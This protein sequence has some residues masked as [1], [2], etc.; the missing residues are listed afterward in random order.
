MGIVALA[1]G[2]FG[3][4]LQIHFEAPVAGT[5]NPVGAGTY[6]LQSSVSATQN[7][8]TLT[9]FTE[10]G[11]GIPYT[12][13]YINSNIVYGTLSPS[14][15]NSEFVSFTGIT[16]NANQTAT[17]SGVI[18]GLART[19]GTGGCVASSTLAH[20]YPGQT[21]FILS[22][23]P[24]FYSQYAVKQN[25]QTIGGLWTFSS[26]SPPKLDYD[27]TSAQ[28]ALF[29]SSTLVTYGQLQATAFAGVTNASESA[30]GIVQLATQTQTGS[31][32]NIGSSGASLVLQS[33]YASSSPSVV[34]GVCTVVTQANG[35]II[36]T[37]INQTSAY[38]WSGLHIFSTGLISTASST[39]TNSSLSIGGLGYTFPSVRGASSTVL[40][41]NGS[42]SLTWESEDLS[43]IYSST[44][45]G[46]VATSS[47]TSI[48]T[49]SYLKILLNIPP[50]TACI[51]QFQFNGDTAANYAYRTTSEFVVAISSAGAKSTIALDTSGTTGLW[52]ELNVSNVANKVKVLRSVG[53]EFVASAS[54]QVAIDTTAT[55]NNTSAQISRI[56]LG[57]G[58]ALP[59]GTTLNIYGSSY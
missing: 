52:S 11:S 49:R 6:V 3:G 39:F 57:C 22:N 17:L 36:S 10:P 56:D 34:C 44:T 7:T 33:Q 58:A 55:W 14:S 42:G 25:A 43:L 40:K 47:F 48:P 13:S 41:E 30:K 26:T 8:I 31:S 15:G 12:M 35:K 16:Q 9:S 21:Q 23:S 24:C 19:P 37:Y 59:T 38:S 50:K 54:D 29:S 51:P 5:F 32:T 45:V 46:V 20:A 27:P 1:A 28:W 53:A 18:R 4:F 2:A